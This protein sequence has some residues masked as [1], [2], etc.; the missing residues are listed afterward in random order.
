MKQLFLVL[1]LA[2][3]ISALS[4]QTIYISNGFAYSTL[5]WK[6]SFGDGAENKQYLEAAVAYAASLGAEYLDKGLFSVR[7][8]LFFSKSGGRFSDTEVTKYGEDSK[9]VI[10]YLSLGTCFNINPLHGKTKLQFSIGPKIDWMVKGRHQPSLDYL[11]DRKS[12]ARFNYG[13]AGGFCLSH[14]FDNTIIGI[15]GWWL[16]HSKKLVDLAIENSPRG[17]GVQA[18]ERIFLLQTAVGFTIR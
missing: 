8:D 16:G 9:V 10:N 7:S 17:F 1:L 4:A 13:L 12:V 3:G 14:V 11:D 5:N 6:Y 2:L 18:S 15:Q